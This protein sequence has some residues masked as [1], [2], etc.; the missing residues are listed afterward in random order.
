MTKAL[1]FDH[2]RARLW[3]AGGGK[4][5]LASLAD[6]CSGSRLGEHW[7]KMQISYPF[8]RA[9]SEPERRLVLARARRARARATKVAR[10]RL[11]ASADVLER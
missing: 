7:C 2:F 10:A 8:D 3:L 9:V 6:G 5:C 1:T 11:S 4:S